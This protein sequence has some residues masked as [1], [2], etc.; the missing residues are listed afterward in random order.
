MLSSLIKNYSAWRERRFDYGAH[1]DTLNSYAQGVYPNKPS[2]GIGQAYQKG[3][4]RAEV[5]CSYRWVREAL[6]EGPV[7]LESWY[8]ASLKGRRI[9][10]KRVPFHYSPK[11]VLDTALGLFDKSWMTGWLNPD[12]SPAMAVI[13]WVETKDPHWC[14][15]HLE[16]TFFSSSLSLWDSIFYHDIDT[17]RW[18]IKEWP[19]RAKETRHPWK[20]WIEN[21]FSWL[22]SI[23]HQSFLF[24]LDKWWDVVDHMALW[25]PFKASNTTSLRESEI[26]S[27]A[28]ELTGIP[29]DASLNM[30]L[31]AHRGIHWFALV[32]GLPPGLT[33][34]IGAALGATW[35]GMDPTC[36][37]I[38]RH[39][40]PNMQYVSW[41][42][43]PNVDISPAQNAWHNVAASTMFFYEDPQSWSAALVKSWAEQLTQPNLY[44]LPENAFDETPAIM[45]I[46]S[47]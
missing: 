47:T 34:P 1:Q 28:I 15:N 10:N 40:Y 36:I 4:L 44:A 17:S 43:S 31:S 12:T 24:P 22:Y 27:R 46:S 37:A 30:E 20:D 7:F 29:T 45:Q 6:N 13:S 3:L 8:D 23:S 42:D 35:P 16:E 41:P 25:S 38:G 5:L 14:G 9:P 33:H 26:L 11:E 2:I 39:F 18:A 19:E 21:K 32:H